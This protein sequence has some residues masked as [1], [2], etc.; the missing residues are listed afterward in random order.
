MVQTLKRIP[1]LPEVIWVASLIRD[2]KRSGSFSKS[3]SLTQ[4]LYDGLVNIKNHSK[5]FEIITPKESNRRG[6]QLSLYFYNNSEEIFQELN[7]NFVIDYRKPN[8]LRVAPVPLY[9]SY[10]E[11]YKFVN[12]LGMLLND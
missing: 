7:K 1:W 12:A 3:K 10:F 6:A 8:V 9:N 2:C 5:Y 4:F 11:V